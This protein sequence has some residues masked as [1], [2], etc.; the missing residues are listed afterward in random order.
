MYHSLWHLFFRMETDRRRASGCESR[1]SL[2]CATFHLKLIV[3]YCQSL[4]LYLNFYWHHLTN[5]LIPC[6]Y[7]LLFLEDNGITSSV[8]L[9]IECLCLTIQPTQSAKKTG[10]NMPGPDTPNVLLYCLVG[11]VGLLLLIVLLYS[12]ISYINDFSNELRYLNN[13]IGRTSG[14]EQACWIRRRKKLW[15]SLIPF[16]RY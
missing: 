3:R 12:F 8:A 11:I 2:I 15:L 9:K 6:K 5:I 16:V 14:A 4:M 1:L 7:S 13:E 10:G